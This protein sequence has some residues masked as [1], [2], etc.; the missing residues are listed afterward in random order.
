[1][2][3]I[4]VF[5]Q[6]QEGHGQRRLGNAPQEVSMKNSESRALPSCLENSTQLVVSGGGVCG[7]GRRVLSLSCSHRPRCPLQG[8]GRGH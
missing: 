5:P 7:W 1:M 6:M 2:R 4:Q 8:G 3:L